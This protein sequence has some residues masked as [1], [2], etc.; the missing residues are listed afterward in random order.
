MNHTYLIHFFNLY[1]S[2]ESKLAAWS[3]LQLLPV[4]QQTTIQKAQRDIILHKDQKY[5]AKVSDFQSQTNTRAS[6]IS[7]GN[8][9]RKT[10]TTIIK[11]KHIPC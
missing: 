8:T 6:N 11:N 4:L 7:T 9:Q 1:L 5:R 3:I 2:R 10:K